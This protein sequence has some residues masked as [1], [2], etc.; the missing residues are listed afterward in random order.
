MKIYPCEIF[1]PTTERFNELFLDLIKIEEAIKDNPDKDSAYKNVAEYHATIR[2]ELGLPNKI[3]AFKADK[4]RTKA[5]IVIFNAEPN[6]NAYNVLFDEE[7]N[8]YIE[9]D[10][11]EE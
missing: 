2:K 7:G 3:I 11:E 9:V 8:P 5:E 1:R 4:A 6:R 10:E